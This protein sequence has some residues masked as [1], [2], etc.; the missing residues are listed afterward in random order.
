[1]VSSN[2]K[3]GGFERKTCKQLSAWLTDGVRDD[4]FWRTSMSGGRATLGLRQ[5]KK[6]EAQAGDVGAIDPLGQAFLS[7][8]SVECKFVKS[9]NLGQML[10]MKSGKTVKFWLK[11]RGECAQYGREPFMVARENRYPT[12][13]FLS[14]AG[15]T[16]LGLE[17]S[18][19]RA[20]FRGRVTMP[21]YAG[22]GDRRKLV[23]NLEEVYVLDWERFLKET[24]PNTHLLR[25]KKS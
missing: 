1:M 12:L 10:A 25:G 21:G 24:L 8:F 17:Y 6:R 7:V 22:A 19:F 23:W 11:H 5:G 4:I 13:L 3:G 20:L 2:A 14:E 15:L 18:A 9:L 16:R